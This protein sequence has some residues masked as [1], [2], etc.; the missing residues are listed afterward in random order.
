MS[1]AIKL[2]GFVDAYQ[3]R[4]HPVVNGLIFYETNVQILPEFRIDEIQRPRK[5]KRSARLPEY[6]GG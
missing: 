4:I 1:S 5:G 3:S 2:H 6:P